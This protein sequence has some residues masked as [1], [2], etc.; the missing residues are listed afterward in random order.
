MTDGP[1]PGALP[2]PPP[3]PPPPGYGAPPPPSTPAPTPR[4]GGRPALWIALGA[5]AVVA[6]AVVAIVV[7]SGGD[8]DDSSEPADLTLADLEPA[9]LTEE[10]VGDDYR[11]DP[12]GGDG[13]DGDTS[14]MEGL[15]GSDECRGVMEDLEESGSTDDEVAVEFTDDSDGTVGN[16]LGLHPPGEPTLA[17]V[18]AAL[19]QCDTMTFEDGGASGEVRIT[20]EDVEGLGNAALGVSLVVDMEVEGLEFTVDSYGVLWEHDG[21]AAD[22]FAFGGLDPGTLEPIPVD[23]EWVFELAQVVDAR[24]DDIVVG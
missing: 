15:V 12:S 1:P 10:D 9:L 23:E 5:V 13:D 3:P 2:P 24:L 16:S 19:E 8:D 20:T 17:D 18:R 7:L 21:V 22:M 14:G 11:L 6:V 4:E